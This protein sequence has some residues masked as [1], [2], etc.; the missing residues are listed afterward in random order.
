MKTPSPVLSLWLAALFLTF[1]P[2]AQA[3]KVSLPNAFPG[4]WQSFGRAV[5]TPGQGSVTVANGFIADLAPKGDSVMSFRARAP[6]DAP[7]VQRF[8]WTFRVGDKVLQTQNN[9]QKEVFNGDIGKV[10][11]INEPARVALTAA[12]LAAIRGLTP[13]EFSQTTTSNARALF[14]LPGDRVLSSP[15]A[16]GTK[17]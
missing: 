8:G 1:T 13:T 7:Q 6:K 4:D 2:L 17:D 5:I 9:Y 10:H 14:R 15:P 12:R 11:E 16:F 3:A